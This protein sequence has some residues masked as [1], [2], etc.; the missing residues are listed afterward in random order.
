M[1]QH[2]LK[3]FLKETGESQSDFAKRIDVSRTT[4]HRIIKREGNFSMG[5]ISDV[6][7]AT[8]GRVKPSDF[9]EVAA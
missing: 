9:F 3:T 1:K 8:G 2:P 7:S 4:V 6:C 5:L